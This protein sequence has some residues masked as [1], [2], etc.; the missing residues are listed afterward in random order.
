MEKTTIFALSSGSPP[1]ALAV[2]RISGPEADAA[3]QQL[4]GRLPQ[5]RR[6]S[7]R[8]LRGADDAVLDQALVLRFPGPD[9]ATGEDLVELHLHG[10]RAVVRA[11]EQALAAMPALRPAAPGEFTRR[12]FDNGRIDLAEAEGLADLLEAETESQRRN[13]LALAGG[14]LSR[15]VDRWTDRLL[16]LSAQAEAV[17]DFADEGDVAT[18]SVDLA[19]LR[20]LSDDIQEALAVPAAERLK[21]GVRIVLAGPPNAGKSSLFNALVGRSAAIVSDIPGT[22]RDRIEAPVALGG[23]PLLLVDTAGLRDAA[24]PVEAIGVERAREGL[25]A[26]DVV[27]WLGEDAGAPPHANLIRIATKVDV[28]AP[29]A[30]AEIA[31]SAVTGT[32]LELLIARLLDEARAFLPGPGEY[33]LNR[34][35]REALRDCQQRL[36]EALASPD[37]L[38][39]A[40]MLRFARDALDRITGRAGI[41]DMLDGLFGRFCIGK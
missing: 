3:L 5:P 38:I 25:D 16:V 11:V 8:T 12:A 28:A 9:S 35:Q 39:V 26:A 2:V 17:L 41:E 20:S 40:E 36:E 29:A 4:A 24:D 32:G 14:A 27:L 15:Q 23:V 13:A 31:V 6:A 37:P 7:L 1:A 21:D 34:R 30:G 10:G 33:A 18:A 19:A 22:T